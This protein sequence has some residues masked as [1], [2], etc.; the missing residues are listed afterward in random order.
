MFHR[1][2]CFALG[3]L[4]LA[5]CA[6][7]N[8]VNVRVDDDSSETRE[9]QKMDCSSYDTRGESLRVGLDFGLLF[10][11]VST[12]PSVQTAKVTGMNWDKSVHH[13]VAQYKELCSRFNSGGISQSAY[14]QRVA[15]V[16][17]FW[18]EAQGIR[19]NAEDAIRGRGQASFGELDRAA[20]DNASSSD[21]SSQSIAV[22]IDILVS[23]LSAR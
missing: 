2:P 21:E 13:M 5:A 11:L 1:F 18:A 6:T 16:D 22:S 14:S 4:S 7:S 10:G 20:P 15:E 19:Q 8:T 17:Q 12:G 9:V 3:L 23:K